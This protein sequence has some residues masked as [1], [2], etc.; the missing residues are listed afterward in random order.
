MPGKMIAQGWLSLPEKKAE[1]GVVVIQE[2]WGLVPHIQEVADR[3]A[4]AGFAAIAPDLWDGKIAKTPDE[5]GRLYMAL[6]IDR[7]ERQIADAVTGLRE[8]AGVKGKVGVVG[9][10]MGGILAVYAASKNRELSAAVDF[11]GGHPKVKPDYAAL[12]ETPVLGVFG[13]KDG[14]V[15]P[16]VGEG[17][18]QEITAAGGTC[19]IHVYPAGHAFFNDHR[20]EVHDAKSAADAWE[21]TLAF[22]RKHL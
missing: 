22:F 21:K 7:A 18:K 19:E 10:C 2:W 17:M 11:Y 5:A 6:E 14:S 13:E 8:H 4:A 15:P 12:R 9:F 16:S 1:R 3:F 20:P